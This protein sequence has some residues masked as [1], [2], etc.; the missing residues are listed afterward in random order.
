MRPCVWTSTRVYVRPDEYNFY[1]LSDDI[2]NKIINLGDEKKWHT[3]NFLKKR[4]KW[5]QT[6]P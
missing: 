2:A 6:I 1:I 4:E 3:E 5:Q